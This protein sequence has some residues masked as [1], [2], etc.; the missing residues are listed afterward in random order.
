[1]TISHR[2][3]AISQLPYFSIMGDEHKRLSILAVEAA[4]EVHYI[5]CCLPV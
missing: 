2:D 4:H 5:L 1:M 3:N